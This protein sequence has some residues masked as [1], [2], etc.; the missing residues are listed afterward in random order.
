NSQTNGGAEG[1]QSLTE[2]SLSDEDSCKQPICSEFEWLQGFCTIGISLDLLDKIKKVMGKQK[3]VPESYYGTKLENLDMTGERASLDVRSETKIRVTTFRLCVLDQK[4]A[5]IFSVSI[6]LSDKHE[7]Q[8]FAIHGIRITEAAMADMVMGFREMVKTDQLSTNH[9]LR[10]F[11]GDDQMR[12]DV[13][14]TSKYAKQVL[15]TGGVAT[16]L[17]GE[18]RYYYRREM[19]D[20]AAF[21]AAST[22]FKANSI[23]TEVYWHLVQWQWRTLE[24]QIH[25]VAINVSKLRN[26]LIKHMGVT[27]GDSFNIKGSITNR[28]GKHQCEH[29]KVPETKLGQKPKMGPTAATVRHEKMGKRECDHRINRW[30]YWGFGWCAGR[31]ARMKIGGIY[32]TRLATIH[33]I[34]GQNWSQQGKAVPDWSINRIEA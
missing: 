7:I 11:A 26:D 15:M 19:T 33:C 21:T 34:C 13:A 6:N 9:V 4:D 23:T 8:K 32:W 30:W 27:H 12:R 10:I 29:A 22:N 31:G 18:Y 16:L 2:G 5:V 25:L 20:N 17:Q 28:S 1:R 3:E 14:I 24:Q